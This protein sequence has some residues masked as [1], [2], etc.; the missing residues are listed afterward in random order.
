MNWMVFEG[1]GGIG[2]W[3]S[4]RAPRMHKKIGS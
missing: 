4:M 3:L 1:F 2:M